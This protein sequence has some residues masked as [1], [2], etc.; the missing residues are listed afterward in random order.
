[1]P[2]S[3]RMSGIRRIAHY[4]LTSHRIVAVGVRLAALAVGALLTSVIAIR[5][6]WSQPATDTPGYAPIN[7]PSMV[8]IDD[9]AYF[10][11]GSRWDNPHV[12][13]CWEPGTPEGADRQLV[14]SA[15]EGSWN[16]AHSHLRFIFSGTC[17]PNAVGVR[18]AVRDDGDSD[19]PYTVGLGNQLNG[20]AAGMVL[21]FTFRT[22]SPACAQSE[23]QRQ[24]CIRSIAVHEFGH[25]A[26]FAHEQNRPDTPGEC[27]KQAQG[28]NGNVMLT[29][30]DPH[31]VMNYCNPVYNNNGVLS[32]MDLQGLHDSR[33]YG[34]AP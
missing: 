34:V 14:V 23:S 27:A 32:A 1:M 24:S 9:K 7:V 31:S 29:P 5:T 28:G 20:K 18:I 30:W 2:T 15:I 25:A 22:W 6:G 16:A 12:L 13:V 3:T 4:A 10:L 26:G 19:G 17:A 21:N 8:R 33:A 11:M